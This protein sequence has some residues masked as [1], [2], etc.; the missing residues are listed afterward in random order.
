MKRR[1][2][3][4]REAKAFKP[5]E[6]VRV[7][8]LHHPRPAVSIDEL[9]RAREAGE[10]QDLFDGQPHA[11][12]A[13][14]HLTYQGGALIQNV[15]IYTIFW[16][17]LWGSNASS[18]EMMTKLNQFFTTIVGSPLLDQLAEYNAPGKTIGHGSFLG[19]QVISANAPSSSITDSAIQAQ[20]LKWLKAK[21]VPKNTKNTLYFIYLD[22]GVVSVMGGSK[23]C[24]N[25]CGYHNNTGKVYYAV[26]PYP[27]CSGCLGGMQA[28]D[29]LTGTSSHELCEAITDP[30][31][32]SGWYDNTNGEIGDICAWN[33]K[34][35][36][37][38]TVQLEWSNQQNKCV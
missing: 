3:P 12:P 13:G 24:Q 16:G 33:F 14:A 36:A 2:K 21:T 18:Q 10:E 1:A 4:A 28:F 8:P 11:A 7:V 5:N 34:Q 29:A 27:T 6:Y 9:A 17:N 23:S 15:Q 35:V 19:T 37:G 26:M 25:Y 31:P 30:V 32:G 38:Y 22:P 20:V